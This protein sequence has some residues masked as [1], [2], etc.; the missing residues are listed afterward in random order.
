MKYFTQAVS[1]NYRNDMNE[2]I[3]VGSVMGEKFIV[4]KVLL[5]MVLR[6]V[7]FCSEFTNKA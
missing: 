2:C 7:L 5:M 3:R 1:S 4:Y 6:V